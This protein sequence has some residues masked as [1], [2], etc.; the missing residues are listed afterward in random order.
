MPHYLFRIEPVRPD[1]HVT[2]PTPQEA[3]AIAAHFGYLQR[4]TELGTV[5]MA[6]RTLALDEKAFGLVLLRADTESQALA[7]MRADPV[8]AQGVMS[9][10]LNP[11]RIALWCNKG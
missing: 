1:M 8:V 5:L 10:E 11:F 2:G 9:G 3:E 6:G 4:L 7:L